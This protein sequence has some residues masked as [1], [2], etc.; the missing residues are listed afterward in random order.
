VRGSQKYVV[1]MIVARYSS[2]LTHASNRPAVVIT[3]IKF[4]GAVLKTSGSGRI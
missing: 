4:L 3:C 2:A 1:N